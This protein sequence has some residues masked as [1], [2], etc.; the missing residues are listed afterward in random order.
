MLAATAQ[1]AERAS[2]ITGASIGRVRL[3]ATRE[4]IRQ[5]YPNHRVMDVEITLEDGG[6]SSALEVRQAAEALITALFSDAG[7]ARQIL[8]QHRMFKT[9]RGVGVG[10]TFAALVRAHGK[11]DTFEFPEGMLFA[12]YPLSDGTIA[13]QLDRGFDD[14]FLKSAQP[15][16][17]ARV[18]RVVVAGR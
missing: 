1:S 2:L 18:V 17:G 8:T 3:G 7:V 9:S 13:F 6:L 16:S 4:A 15:P 12:L 5:A 14:V 11:P 10:S